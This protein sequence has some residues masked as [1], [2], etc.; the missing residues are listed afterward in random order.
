MRVWMYAYT[1]KYT[2][3][4]LYRIE[5]ERG[6]KV[7]ERQA[8]ANEVCVWWETGESESARKSARER[9]RQNEKATERY[10]HINI[11]IYV[12][13]EEC[14]EIEREQKT[15][16]T[17]K[18]RVKSR[19]LAIRDFQFLV[20]FLDMD[21]DGFD[22]LVHDMFL[23]CAAARRPDAVDKRHTVCVAYTLLTLPSRYRHFP[24][25]LRIYHLYMYIYI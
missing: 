17:R 21:H 24:P 23:V 16:H 13:T 25:P 19:Y 14:L 11:Y 12:Y 5:R 3:I 2:D 7:G 9:D 6:E 10:M 22:N 1:C 20:V 8:R 18:I 4:H 15:K